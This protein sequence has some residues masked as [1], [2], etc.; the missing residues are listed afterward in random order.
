MMEN[1][2]EIS[3]KRISASRAIFIACWLSYAA[4][5]M[6]KSV[7]SASMASMIAEGMFTKSY[8]GIINSGFYL[9]YG[10]AQLLGGK[11]IDKISPIIWINISMVGTALSML[12]MAF[13]DGFIPMLVIWSLDG[14]LQFAIWPAI[15]RVIAEYV[16]PSQRKK[17]MTL[18]SFSYCAGMLSSYLCGSVVL[19][20][21]HW[22]VF[23][24][25]A[26]VILGGFS[27]YWILASRASL[28]YLSKNDIEEKEVSAEA[29]SHGPK[30][31]VIISSGLFLLFIPSFIRTCLDLGLKSWVPTMIMESYD[32]S[33]SF[34]NALTTVLVLI[35]LSGVFFCTWLYPKIVKN[36]A[37]GFGICFAAALPMTV[38]LLFTG[39]IPVIA[40]VL[41]LSGL[42]TMMYAGH[43]FNNVI[44]PMFFAKYHKEGSIAGILNAIA[45]FGA[46]AATFGFGYL[47]DNFGWTGTIISWIAITATALIFCLMASPAF[48]RFTKE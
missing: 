25:V 17:A 37:V 46:V 19:S 34:A 8:S 29:A 47:A 36:A 43:Q 14:L 2:I 22:R 16:I 30:K 13:A 31:S 3:Q 39:K 40:V 38:L 12:G 5:S 45:S 11:L 20:F 32:V 18:I 1:D 33:A 41:L 35:N 10:G 21:A 9:L 24:I 7:Y 23:F 44:I 48:G 27:V 15:V 4:I 28:K 6:G 26:A 42:T